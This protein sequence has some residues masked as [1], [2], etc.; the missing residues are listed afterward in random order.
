MA[1][2]RYRGLT[3]RI[4]VDEKIEKMKE[5]ENSRIAVIPAFIGTLIAAICL[6]FIIVKIAALAEG[7]AVI[8]SFLELMQGADSGSPAWR[9]GWFF[10]DITEGN[11]I[12]SLPASI[13]VII[14]SYI[15]YRLEKKKSPLA[16]TGVDGNSDI[17]IPMALS[18]FLS[19]IIG[20]MIFTGLFGQGVFVPSFATFL[21]VQAMVCAFKANTI[22]KALT[23]TVLG[24][25]TELP[26]C[27]WVV[28][29]FT[30][31]NNLPLFVA[32]GISIVITVPL[33]SEIF[34][35]LP[36]MK[37]TE[38]T[39]APVEVIE[40]VPQKK[41]ENAF[42]VNRVFGDVAEM[43]LW[44]SSIGGIFLYIGC[45]ISVIMNPTHAAF[46]IADVISTQLATGALAVFIWYP[47][48][49][50]DGWAFTFAPLLFTTAIVCTYGMSLKIMIPSILIAAVCIPPL[51]PR[52]M[53]AIKWSGRWAPIACILLSV[54]ALCIPWSFFVANVLI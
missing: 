41:S 26:L 23:I 19:L 25:V 21:S 42:F 2:S 37:A 40:E 27:F 32:V 15:G 17:F 6:Y 3:E 13:M 38:E 39:P 24:T 45:I 4:S 9:A 35:R 29:H 48:W 46:N 7:N 20:P 52:I 1:E 16:G 14:G 51:I 8:Y 36:W 10:A 31:P 43:I 28:K 5:Q 47:T 18:G 12:G 50:K 11:F 53:G 34:H 22:P 33:C 30:M 54:I 49:K 44:G